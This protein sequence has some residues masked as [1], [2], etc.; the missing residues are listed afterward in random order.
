MR[1]KRLLNKLLGIE[2]GNDSLE[3]RENL[4]KEAFEAHT[5][6]AGTERPTGDSKETLI[7]LADLRKLKFFFHCISRRYRIKYSQHSML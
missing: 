7:D 5:R 1:H 3:P 6:A 4:C 2:I